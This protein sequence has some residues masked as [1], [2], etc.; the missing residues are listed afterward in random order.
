MDDALLNRLRKRARHLDAWA[1]REGVT[2]YRLFD[3]DV[4]GWHFAVDR[5][6]DWLVVHEYPWK[7]GDPLHARRRVELL[8]ACACVLGVPA[9]RTIVKSHERHRWGE[10]QYGRTGPGRRLEVT[11]GGLRFEV[12]ISAHL[13][14]GLFLDHRRTRALVRGLSRGRRV[15]NLFSYT[16]AFSVYAGA[17]GASRVVS[18]DLSAVYLDWARRNL[19]RNGLDGPRQE[20]RREEV[21]AFVRDAP[22]GQFDLIVLD[23]PSRS[24]SRGV[25]GEFQVQRDHGELLAGVAALLSP[26]GVLVF[27][28]NLRDFV[29]K[30]GALRGDHRISELTPGSLPEDFRARPPHRCWRIERPAKPTN[31]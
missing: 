8:D 26:G 4:P 25:P 1:R 5:Y 31:R 9:D 30:P 12:D 6:A 10:S 13:D 21:R 17:G 19:A 18:V 29:L 7:P 3:R 28:T 20:L 23:P 24:A 2:A 22:R 16:G 15:L 11:E 14:T 27:S